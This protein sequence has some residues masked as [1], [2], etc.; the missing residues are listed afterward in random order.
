[1]ETKREAN[2]RRFGYMIRGGKQ[3]YW[4]KDVEYGADT[5]EE[6]RNHR[7]DSWM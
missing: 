7:E 6:K 4:I 3:I 2:L 1:M 5:E